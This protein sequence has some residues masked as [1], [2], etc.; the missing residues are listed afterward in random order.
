MAWYDP[1]GWDWGQIGRAA[2]VAFPVYGLAHAGFGGLGGLG[3]KMQRGFGLGGGDVPYQPTEFRDA[4]F[5][6]PAFGTYSPDA[7]QGRAGPQDEFRSRQTQLADALARR[8]RGEMPS[9]AEMQLRE[10]QQRTAAMLNSLAASATGVS[11]GAALRMAQGGAIESNAAMNTRAAQLRAQ[12]QAEAEARLAAL[13]ASGRTGDLQNTGLNDAMTRFYEQQQLERDRAGLG[14][15]IERARLRAAENQAVY[16]AAARDAAARDAARGQLLQ[17]AINTGGMIFGR[18]A[19][20][21][22]SGSG[23]GSGGEE[24]SI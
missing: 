6:I 21:S 7:F 3:D 2:D 14:A 5:S 10:G 15:R 8:A 13:L 23:G 1:R 18:L 16:A 17:G 11:P 19:G 22:L 9:A 4:D 20:N 12:E 24:F